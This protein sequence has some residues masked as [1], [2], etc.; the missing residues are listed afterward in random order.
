MGARQPQL[1]T[2]AQ[3][4][5]HGLSC[6]GSSC[7]RTSRRHQVRQHLEGVGWSFCGNNIAVQRRISYFAKCWCVDRCCYFWWW[8]PCKLEINGGSIDA[9]LSAIEIDGKTITNPFIWS[10][11]LTAPGGFA[12]NPATQAFLDDNQLL[13]LQMLVRL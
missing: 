9:A 10:A 2:A 7:F 5:T 13:S 12:G 6:P 8:H 11:G 3:T 4:H 1:W